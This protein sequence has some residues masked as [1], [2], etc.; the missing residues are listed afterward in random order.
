MKSVLVMQPSAWAFLV[1][2][3]SLKYDHDSRLL[4]GR[5]KKISF[6]LNWN[7]FLVISVEIL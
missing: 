6:L 4:N 3:F 2:D 7:S 5:D 1:C